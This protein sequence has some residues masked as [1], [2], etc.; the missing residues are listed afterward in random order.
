[1]NKANAETAAFLKKYFDVSSSTIPTDVFITRMLQEYSNVLGNENV[2][3]IAEDFTY[4]IHELFDP[5]YVDTRDLIHRTKTSG[6]IGL[7]LQ[8]FKDIKS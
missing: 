2:D 8:V 6:M 5:E 1:M 3:Q 4:K 7:I